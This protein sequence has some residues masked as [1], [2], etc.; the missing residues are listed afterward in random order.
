M[1]PNLKDRQT[2]EQEIK[3]I[4]QLVNA[5]PL[6]PDTNSFQKCLDRIPYLDLTFKQD[7]L[8]PDGGYNSSTWR[9]IGEL[10]G[11]RDVGCPSCWGYWHMNGK[12]YVYRHDK[13][14]IPERA[15]K[16]N[17]FLL[18]HEAGHWIHDTINPKGF[19]ALNW[20]CQQY[21]PRQYKIT[22]LFEIFADFVECL[23][24]TEGK[25]AKENVFKEN[26]IYLRLI[27]RLSFE[28]LAEVSTRIETGEW[29]HPFIEST[30]FPLK[31][32]RYVKDW[33]P[34][35]NLGLEKVL[36]ELKNNH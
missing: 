32:A 24:K 4:L 22:E 13:I 15:F 3:K 17:P 12:P 31:E 9:D 20:G 10:K 16:I 35:F 26:L 36:E 6:F 25:A 23:Y 30:E 7:K 34:Q 27:P 21:M 5:A 2:F 28:A 11:I 18:G 19:Y 8:Y 14:N 29:H 1:A 33:F